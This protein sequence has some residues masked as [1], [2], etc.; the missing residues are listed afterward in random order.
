MIYYNSRIPT[1]KLKIPRKNIFGLR[2]Q[3]FC[4]SQV[5]DFDLSYL[6][7]AAVGT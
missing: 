7:V 1:V 5:I 3:N 6:P 2:N 4:Y